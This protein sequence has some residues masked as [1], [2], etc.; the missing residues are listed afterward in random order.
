MVKKLERDLERWLE[1]DVP[2]FDVT[3]KSLEGL[4]EREAG[5]GIYS[6]GEVY[7]CDAL[8]VVE[9]AVR[10]F[11]IELRLERGWRSGRIGE[12]KGDAASALTLERTLLNFLIHV[13]SI[14]TETRRVRELLDSRG[15]EGVRVAVTRKTVPGMRTWAKLFASCAGADTHRLGLSDMVMIKDTHLAAVKDFEKA[16][17][18]ASKRKSFSHKLEVEVSTREQAL[19]ALR[20]ADVI[21][22]DN[23]T[24]EAAKELACEL[25]SSRSDVVVEVSGGI[26]RENVLQYLN[27]CVDVVSMGYLTIN[28]PRVDLSMRALK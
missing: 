28:P 27:D 23:F 19:K 21:M 16:L 10:S 12:V 18:E 8:E 20:Y 5:F 4:L 13:V 25:K 7:L 17:M 24:P 2:Y 14:S 11:G 15:Y 26:S 9:V 1:E 6:K 3:V 22:L